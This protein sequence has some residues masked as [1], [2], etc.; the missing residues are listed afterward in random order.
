MKANFRKWILHIYYDFD[1]VEDY[2]YS[3]S[4]GYGFEISET[5][6]IELSGAA[7]YAGKDSSAGI[8][9]GFH[10][11]TISVAASYCITEEIGISATIAF[12]DTFDKDVLPEQDVDLYGGVGISYFF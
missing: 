12:T 10:D 6:S 11:Y 7:G 9:S 3:L 5:L 4:L 1:E 8:E 2:Y